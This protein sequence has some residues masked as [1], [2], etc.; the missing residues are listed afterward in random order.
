MLNQY[1][2]ILCGS[3]IGVFLNADKKIII[4][5]IF[6]VIGGVIGGAIYKLINL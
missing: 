3:L 4:R 1:A 6:G 2:Y 5:L